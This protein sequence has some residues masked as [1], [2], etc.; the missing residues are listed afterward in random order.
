MSFDSPDFL[1]KKIQKN[2]SPKLWALK[3]VKKVKCVPHAKL[4]RILHEFKSK[5]KEK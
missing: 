2:R 1:I 3:R 4:A 5:K